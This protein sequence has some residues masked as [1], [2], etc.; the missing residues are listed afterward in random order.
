MS[1]KKDTAP[2]VV[3][4]ERGD[5]DALSACLAAVV[6][7]LAIP[8]IVLEEEEIGDDFPAVLIVSARHLPMTLERARRTLER[9]AA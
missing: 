9:L 4:A 7:S 6:Q 1:H 3:S 5:D 2:Y 8:V